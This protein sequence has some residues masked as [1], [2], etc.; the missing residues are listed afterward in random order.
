MTQR[1]EFKHDLALAL[2]WTSVAALEQGM[3][4]REYLRWLRYALKKDLPQRRLEMQLANIAKW[5]AQSMGYDDLT[6]RDFLFDAPARPSET[7][8]TVA[9][10]LGAI[11]GR[12]VFKLSQGRK[13]G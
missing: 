2:G 1:E 12:K 6:L 9:P 7:V 10:V 11:T 5:I 3:S 4:Q 13:R 8:A